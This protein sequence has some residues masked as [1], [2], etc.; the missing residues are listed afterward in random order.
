MTTISSN[1]RRKKIRAAAVAF[2]LGI[3]LIIG[4]GIIWKGLASNLLWH[5]LSPILTLRNE[6]AVNQVGLLGMISSSAALALE[7]QALR[8]EIASSSLRAAD[9]DILFQ[10]NI[11][12]KRRLNRVS[13]TGTTT[14][15]AV[16]MRP[17]ALR[18]V[19]SC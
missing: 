15:A 6:A 4:T 18:T 16:L 19:R 3:I 9:R 2:F 8:E 1:R 5:V 12:L 10:E 11:D 7:N 13:L 17:P 14:L